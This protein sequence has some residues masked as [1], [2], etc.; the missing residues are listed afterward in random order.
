MIELKNVKLHPT[1]PA[2][3]LVETYTVNAIIVGC[4]PYIFELNH[5]INSG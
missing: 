3:S 5:R 1:I 2:Y 4:S